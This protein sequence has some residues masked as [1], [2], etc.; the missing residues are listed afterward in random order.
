MEN[1]KNQLYKIAIENNGGEGKGESFAIEMKWTLSVTRS[2]ETFTWKLI[3][4][5]F[6]LVFCVI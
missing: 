1:P 3:F 2:R 6:K 4:F 5:G